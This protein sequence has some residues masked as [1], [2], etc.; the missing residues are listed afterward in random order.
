[1]S[2]R[3]TDIEGNWKVVDYPQHPECVGCKFEI[4]GYGF[5]PNVFKLNIVKY[6]NCILQHKPGNK[7]WE[8]SNLFSTEKNG[9]PEERDKANP[10]RKLVFGLEKLEVRNQQQLIIKTNNDEQVR[11]KR[12]PW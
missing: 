2:S 6:L 1:M 10:F 3:I 8:I 12:L 4:K 9:S 11:L 5:D 7:K